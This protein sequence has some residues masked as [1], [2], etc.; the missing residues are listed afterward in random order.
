[1]TVRRWLAAAAA[2]AALVL[3]L[4]AAAMAHVEATVGGYA[5]EVGWL[6]EPAVQGQLNGLDVLVLGA[7]GSQP[8]T[9]LEKTLKAEVS[10][11]DQHETLDLEPQAGK[12][13][14]YTA[15]ILPSQPGDYRV[16]LFGTIAGAAFDHTYDLGSDPDMVVQPLS[17]V[18]FPAPAAPAA[19]VSATPAAGQAA[20]APVTPAAAAS[21]AW[22]AWL[23]LGLAAV[24]LVVS[25]LPRGRA[26][27]P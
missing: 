7:A 3:A 25:L 9:G 5:T 1:M 16:R 10:F 26:S 13:G 2:A 17:A 23:A 4:P 6:Q 12:P 8:V 27:R 11:G 14:R 21:P 24:A 19:T 22:P 15:P 18:A 20:A